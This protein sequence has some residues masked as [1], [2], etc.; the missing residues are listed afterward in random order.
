MVKLMYE[1]SWLNI[2]I[3]GEMEENLFEPYIVVGRF[4]V[5]SGYIS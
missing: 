3:F 2:L 5:A 1:N 4:I